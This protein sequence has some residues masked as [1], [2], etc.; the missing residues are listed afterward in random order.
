[1]NLILKP[2]HKCRFNILKDR[3]TIESIAEGLGR[4]VSYTRG[5]LSGTHEPPEDLHAILIKMLRYKPEVSR[6]EN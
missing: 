6:R 3:Y 2:K 4:S 1:M 5:I